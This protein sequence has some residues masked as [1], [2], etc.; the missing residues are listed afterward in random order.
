[1][2]V[3]N[4]HTAEYPKIQQIKL[5]QSMIRKRKMKCNEQ[6]QIQPN[7]ASRPQNQKGK[8]HTHELNN[9]HKRHAQ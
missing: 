8:K 5:M 1:M 7:L 2:P 9:A 3:E 6:G 4:A